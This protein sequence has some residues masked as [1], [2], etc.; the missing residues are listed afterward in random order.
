MHQCQYPYKNYDSNFALKK[1]KR[2]K[3]INKKSNKILKK[4]LFETFLFDNQEPPNKQEINITDEFVEELF[5][6]QLFI[7]KL[8]SFLHSQSGRVSEESFF[9]F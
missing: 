6:N 9:F 7:T 1:K 2:K 5:Q 8:H 3:K 4:W